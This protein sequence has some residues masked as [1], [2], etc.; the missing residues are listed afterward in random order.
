MLEDE[1]WSDVEEFPNYIISSFGRIKHRARSEPRQI[2]LNERG[3]PIVVLFGRWGRESK[4]RYLRQ[5]NKLVATAFLL[6]PIFEDQTAVWHIDG[7]LTNC[8][9]GNLRWDTRS[10]VLEWNEMHR[11]GEP[12]LRT[13]G[14]RNNRTG[15]EYANA[16]ECAMA[17][18]DIESKIVWRIERQARHMEDDS[19]RY[20]YIY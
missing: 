12:K 20:R 19:A 16:Y 18:G 17:E 10:R 9:V 14:V 13:P 7:D 15:Q 11:S 6:S 4:T 8:H 1:E 2:T 3:F 5:I